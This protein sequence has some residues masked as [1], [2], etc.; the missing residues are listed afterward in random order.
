MQFAPQS[1]S[2][3]TQVG[4]ARTRV[5][6]RTVKRE[7]AVEAR[8]NVMSVPAD[9]V[10]G[11]TIPEIGPLCLPSKG[12]CSHARALDFPVD[13][14]RERIADLRHRQPYLRAVDQPGAPQPALDRRRARLGKQE[15]R[16]IDQLAPGAQRTRLIAGDMHVA[17]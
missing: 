6:S 9:G 2:W 15:A 16:E 11:P 3:R 5:R 1:A 4:P 10:G 7:S 12:S 17:D 14:R 13:A 8:G